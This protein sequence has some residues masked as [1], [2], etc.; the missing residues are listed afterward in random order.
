MKQKMDFFT[1]LEDQQ[2]L[3]VILNIWK[4]VFSMS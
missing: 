3:L 1:I 2:N 4:M